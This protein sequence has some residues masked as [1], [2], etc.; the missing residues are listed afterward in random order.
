[1]TVGHVLSSAPPCVLILSR[2][3]GGTAAAIDD[4]AASLARGGRI[5]PFWM[6][7]SRSGTMGFWLL[8]AS[9]N[10]DAISCT[11][12][13]GDSSSSSLSWIPA[14]GR[15]ENQVAGLQLRNCSKHSFVHPPHLV[16]FG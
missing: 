1:M 10:P 9:W 2:F 6:S 7:A 8:E 16:D 4:S 15:E 13:L 5:T 11:V 14:N 3:I 12:L